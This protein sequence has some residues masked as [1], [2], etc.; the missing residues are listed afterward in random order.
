MQIFDAMMPREGMSIAGFVA[1]VTVYL[2]LNSSLNLLNKVSARGVLGS[3]WRGLAVRDGM[4]F[5]NL[6]G[7]ACVILP[8]PT[9]CTSH[10]CPVI[11]VA[12]HQQ[13]CPTPRQRHLPLHPNK[14]RISDPFPSTTQWALGIYGFRF[15]FLLTTAHMSFSFLVLAPF[16]LRT[17]WEAHRATLRRSWRGVVYIGAFMALNIALNNVSLQDISLTLNQVIRSAIPAV[18]CLLA[19]FVEGHVPSRREAAGVLTLTLGVMAVV[20]QGRATG[21]A[22][23]VLF[24]MAATVCNGAMMTFSGKVMS[25]KLDVV[26]LTF[27]TAPV[28]LF[29]LLPFFLKFEVRRQRPW[30]LGLCSPHSPSP[31]ND[32]PQP[33]PPNP[34]T[35][36]AKLMAYLPENP[37]GA[38]YVLLLTSINALAYNL[39]HTLMIKRTSAVT[40]TVLGMIKIVGLLLL[41]TFL[42]GEGRELTPSMTAGCIMAVTGFAV[43]SHTRLTETRATTGVRVISLEG[44]EEAGRPVKG[45]GASAAVFRQPSTP[46]SS[47]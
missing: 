11:G 4:P 12:L 13:P 37:Q 8:P 20:W 14:S 22:Y 3:R 29:C 23:A 31:N 7:A 24:C 17:P 44:D 1:L 43:Y 40:T 32:D 5:T 45:L 35:Q 15:P 36:L 39:V 28:S 6:R 10:P 30:A 34:T 47:E 21:R 19:V 41:S 16:A 18:T 42:L 46:K 27:Y 38:A 26:S 25:E 33:H 9:P 2:G